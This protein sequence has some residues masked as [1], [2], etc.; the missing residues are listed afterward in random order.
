MSGRGRQYEVSEWTFTSRKGYKDPFNQ[1]ELDVV[2]MDEESRA[3]KV[4]AFWAGGRKWRVRFA[5]PTP[6]HYRYETIC[7]D[8]A[9]GALHGLTGVLDASPHA[10]DNPLLRHGPIQ[11]AGDG[12]HLEHADGTPFFWLG[13]TWWMGLTKRLSWPKGFQLLANDRVKKGFTV[14]QI[15]AGL[16]PDMPAFDKR[17]A[18]EAG[19]PWEKNY[20]RVNPSYFDR[21]DVRIQWLVKSGLVPCIVGCWGYFLPL[22]GA[23]KLKKHWRYLV[24]RYGAYPVAWC[25]AGEWDMPYYLS[26]NGTKDAELQKTKWADIARYVKSINVFKRPT[27]IHEGTPGRELGDGT[28]IDFEMLQTGH[29]DRESLPNT[30]KRVTGEYAAKPSM[31]VI[32]SEV[33]YE[34]IGEACRQEVQRLMFWTCMLSGAAGHTYGAN[35]IW[36]VNTRAKPYGPSPHGMAW[37]NTPWEDAYQL[38]GSGH[39]GLGKRLLARYAW[40][41]FEPHSEWVDPHW[42]EKNYFA[43]FAA[44]IPGEVRVLYVPVSWGAPTM[45]HVELD[46]GYRAYLFNP[47]DGVETDLGA[48]KPDANGDWLL[49]LQKGIHRLL[50]IFQDWVIVLET[51][52]ARL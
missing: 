48:V 7:S 11:V 34:G 46:R 13:D 16:Y 38:P 52:G 36:Q 47:A 37:G 4:P 20:T 10:G 51:K 32:N 43:P 6:G 15:I 18:N 50:P 40:W 21:A 28:L 3:W 23:D 25:L 26:K 42:T 19:F 17:G 12:R 33:C 1:V 30:V 29:G 14:V 39:L 27:S 9:N 49:P 45:K 2:F 22:M 8:T 44:G 35:G 5:P 24:A 31:P 41:K